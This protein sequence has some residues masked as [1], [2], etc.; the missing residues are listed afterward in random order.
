MD[1]KKPPKTLEELETE[2]VG[3]KI[4]LSRIEEFLIDMP[5]AQDYLAVDAEDAE[6]LEE[7]AKVVVQYDRASASLLQR[8][9][10][11]GY[12]RAIRLIEMLADK[13]IIGKSDGT[14]KPREVLVSE[15]PDDF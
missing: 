6:L 13:G 8:R 4:R 5:V 10:S 2:V 14:S 7:A 15:I 9:L 3:L 11:I 12:T 1:N